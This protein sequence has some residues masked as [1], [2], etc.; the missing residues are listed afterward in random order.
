[1]PRNRRKL[2]TARAATSK[3]L[4]ETEHHAYV[5]LGNYAEGLEGITSGSPRLHG[6]GALAAT[7][8]ATMLATAPTTS[9][10][11]A[12]PIPSAVERSLVEP[13]VIGHRGASGYRPEHLTA[14]T[15]PPLIVRPG[16]S[17]AARLLTGPCGLSA[18]TRGDP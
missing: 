11:A 3:A 10:A 8:L 2:A 14:A 1:M 9:A 5:V 4:R 18:Q 12:A 15:Y 16:P 6:R 17:S 7:M 13:V